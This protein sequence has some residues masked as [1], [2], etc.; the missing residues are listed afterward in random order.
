VLVLVAVV[1]LFLMF[2][3]NLFNGGTAPNVRETLPQVPAVR[4]S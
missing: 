4:L 2:K 3:F 1:I